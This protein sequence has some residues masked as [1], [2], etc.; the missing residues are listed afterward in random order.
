M[1]FGTSTAKFL[2]TCCLQMLSDSLK[3]KNPF[4][5]KVISNDFYVNDL[6]TGSDS[7]ET[8]TKLT[9]D[10]SSILENTGFKL[11]KWF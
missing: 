8:V 4:I 6:L 10:I 9:T 7:I 3:T 1:T 2:V 11:A 5:S